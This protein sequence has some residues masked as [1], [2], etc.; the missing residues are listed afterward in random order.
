M[1][2]MKRHCVETMFHQQSTGNT[3]MDSILAADSNSGYEFEFIRSKLSI[4]IMT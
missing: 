2:K 1:M 4:A 3:V